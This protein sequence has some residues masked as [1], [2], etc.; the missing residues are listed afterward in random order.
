MKKELEEM[1][2]RVKVYLPGHGDNQNITYESPFTAN[3]LNRYQKL[4]IKNEAMQ[5]FENIVI[6]FRMVGDLAR[7]I[8]FENYK[9][10]S[11]ICHTVSDLWNNDEFF[12]Y[13]ETAFELISACYLDSQEPMVEVGVTLLAEGGYLIKRPHIA[14]RL[15]SQVLK[16]QNKLYKWERPLPNAPE[17]DLNS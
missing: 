8:S 10:F 1:T 4:G 15:L 9:K 13:R 14:E 5:T 2:L 3:I 6:K 12:K 16:V 17:N 11:T 7:N